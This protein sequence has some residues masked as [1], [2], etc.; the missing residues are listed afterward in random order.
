MGCAV[1]DELESLGA[2]FGALGAAEELE[3]FEAVIVADDVRD[4]VGLESARLDAVGR[5]RVGYGRLEGRDK[6][7]SLRC[8]D[9]HEIG[10]CKELSIGL[11]WKHCDFLEVSPH[12]VEDADT[13]VN[14]DH[15]AFHGGYRCLSLLAQRGPRVCSIARVMFYYKSRLRPVAAA[16][17]HQKAGKALLNCPRN[18]LAHNSIPFQMTNRRKIR[19]FGLIA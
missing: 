7:S 1:R 8:L 3:G 15:A 19:V 17:S 16:S 6:W 13:E 18:H 4:P 5:G 10:D 2:G 14:V 9:E 11:E 12:K